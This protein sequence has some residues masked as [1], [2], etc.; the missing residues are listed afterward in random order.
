MKKFLIVTGTRAEYGL[1]R[2]L[3][4]KLQSDLAV[5]THV[6]VTGT[7]LSAA[8]GMTI[9]MI[10]EDNVAN[11]HLVDLKI[12]G[13]QPVDVC[14]GM[15]LGLSGFSRLLNSLRPDLLIVL[16]D[17]YELWPA[18]MAA[19]IGTTPIAH[20][21]GGESTEGLIDEA[22]RHSITK[23]SHLHLCSHEKY[24]QRI[25]QMGE[26]PKRVWNVGAVGLDRIKEMK[27]LTKKE[28]EE[29]LKTTLGEINVL[30]TFHPV[31]LNEEQSSVEIN[32]LVA[33]IENLISTQP[34]KVFITLP[35]SD[36][37][38]NKIRKAWE[39]LIQRNP[40]RVFG[41]VNL[42]DLLYLSLMKEVDLVLGNSSSG[43]L[44]AP[45][46]R[47]AIVDVG[48]RQ[49][50]RLRSQHIIHSNG[51]KEDL[52]NA[53]LKALSPEF[54][55]MAKNEPSIYGEGESV[56]KI[57]KVLTSENLDNIIFKKFYEGSET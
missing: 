20:I 47:K 57:Y 8:H 45:F 56:E 5:E 19:T 38:S 36:T 18:T 11:I 33:A 10:K 12:K 39:D 53:I 40:S 22:V 41:Y 17:R 15:A 21:H 48:R 49:D 7:H 43:I 52:K 55:L 30:C 28:I 42:G 37:F 27:F 3:I 23:M 6:A 44:E 35:N 2:K 1:L 51:T 25:I 4:L 16:G 14:D 31:T 54:K 24:R 34:A 29:R 32:E 46:M 26:N 13:D 9:N 50:G